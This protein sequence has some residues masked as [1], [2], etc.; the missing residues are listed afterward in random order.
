M[1]EPIRLA[2]LG[3]GFVTGVHSRHLRKLRSD[4]TWG[5]ASR[6]PAKAEDYQRRY[7][8]FAAFPSYEA[9]LADPRV[10]A[11]VISVPPTLHAPLALQALAAGKHVLIEK[12][13]LKIG[14]A[15]V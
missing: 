12:P 2:F 7:G 5:Y 4:F 6:V 9:A 8:G 14:R 1:P 3:C 13:A 15:H 11:V 10:D